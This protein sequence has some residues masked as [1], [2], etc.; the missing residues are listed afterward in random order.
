MV[1]KRREDWDAG[2]FHG[3]FRSLAQSSSEETF[4]GKF[5]ALADEL[6]PLGRE[7]VRETV[8]CGREMSAVMEELHGIASRDR[9]CDRDRG[10]RQECESLYQDVD[11]A[12]EH[13]REMRGAC[14]V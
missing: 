6:E 3:E 5:H 10:F 4:R 13:V 12:I 2:D 7:F 11:R 9:Y 14:F 8:G 1:T